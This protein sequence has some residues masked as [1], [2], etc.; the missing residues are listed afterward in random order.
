[1]RS[2]GRRGDGVEVRGSSIRIRFTWRGKRWRERLPG[3]LPTPV[4]EKYAKRLAVEI[5]RRIEAGTFDY[6]EFFPDSPS[7][8]STRDGVNSGVPPRTVRHYGALW[9][10]SRSDLAEHSRYDYGN[11]LRFWYARPAQEGCVPLGDRLAHDVGH[12]ELAALVG[13]IKWS[14]PKMRNNTLIPLRSLFAFAAKDGHFEDP[15]KDIK[16]ATEEEVIPDPFD[17]DEREAVLDAI[18]TNFHEQIWNYYEVAFFTGLRPQEQIA[19]KWPDVDWRSDLIFIR[20]A[21]KKDGD[22]PLKTYKQRKV[23]LNSRSRIAFKRQ[24][25]WTYAKPHAYVFENP[26]TGNPWVRRIGELRKIIHSK[27]S[28]FADERDTY[29]ARALR[30]AKVR[31]RTPYHTHAIPLSLG[32]L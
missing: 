13:D 21:R 2:R 25:K 23:R 31:Y 8:I 15:A 16:N 32:P 10:Q 20:R 27:R 14:S 9:L 12:A 4:N 24:M 6:A 18:R 11:A 29:F 1:M 30:I 26:Q 19:L 17:E 3:R 7:A 28:E 5:N 22:G